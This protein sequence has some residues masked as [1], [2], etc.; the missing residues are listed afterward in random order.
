MPRKR[1]GR[2]VNGIL[3]LNK[4]LGMTSNKALQIVKRAYGAAKAGHTGSLDPAASGLLPICF[5]EATKLSSFLLDSDKEYITTVQL[6]QVTNTAD[7]DGEVIET[8]NVLELVEADI[9]EV[10][11]QFEGEISQIPPM[12]SALKQDGKR[13]YEL[14]HKGIEVER[15]ARLVTINSL[16]LLKIDD[17]SKQI[18]L[19]VNC[20]KGTYIRTLAEDIG[21][22]LGYGGHVKTLHRIKTGPFSADDMVDFEHFD[23]FEGNVEDLAQ[24]LLPVDVGVLHLP[25]VILTKDIAKEVLQGQT[26]RISEDAPK[27]GLLR[28]YQDSGAF[29]GIGFIKEEGLIAP[30][31]LFNL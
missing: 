28:L 31:R 23:Y 1:K 21:K 24:Y 26:V 25:K 15:E 9:Y 8:Y 16:T 10:L 19:Q 2:S 18:E 5:G 20:S 13:L 7:A 22:V 6:G 29:L 30:K 11:K 3:L 17:D 14:A 4:P 27:Q 12:Y